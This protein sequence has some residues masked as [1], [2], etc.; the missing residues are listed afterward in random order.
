M[1]CYDILLELTTDRLLLIL[2]KQKVRK[3]RIS[4]MDFLRV[5]HCTPHP[6]LKI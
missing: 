6:Q 5:W 1:A 2:K 3:I 4:M